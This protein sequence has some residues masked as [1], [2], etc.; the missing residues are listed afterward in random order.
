MI[1]EQPNGLF[2]RFSHTVDCV[3]HYNM[4]VED[5]ARVIQER[6]PEKSP[7][8]CLSE[9]RDITTNH[10]Y[11]FENVMGCVT[12]ANMTQEESDKVYDEMHEDVKLE[13]KMKLT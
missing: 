7:E 6:S 2:C 9:A 3:T 10:L 8:K 13:T 5:Y 4:T 12:T 11:D 1:T